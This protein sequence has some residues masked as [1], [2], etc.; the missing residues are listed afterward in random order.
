VELGVLLKILSGAG[1]EWGQSREDDEQWPRP[2]K[3]FHVVLQCAKKDE[4]QLNARLE[5]AAAEVMRL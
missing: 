3:A 2:A 4:A 5:S 1:E